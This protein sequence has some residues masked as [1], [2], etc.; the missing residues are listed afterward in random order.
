MDKS[1][2]TSQI[3]GNKLSISMRDQVTYQLK[4]AIKQEEQLRRL[5]KEG[6]SD[7]KMRQKSMGNAPMATS[8]A[9]QEQVQFLM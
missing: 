3:Q 9:N 1:L 5:T 7:K 6:S 2:T 4:M 8:E